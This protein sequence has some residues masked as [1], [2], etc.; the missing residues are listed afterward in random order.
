MA[1]FGSTCCIYRPRAP[2]G[3]CNGVK[4]FTKLHAFEYFLKQNIL[5]VTQDQYDSFLF[6]LRISH[7]KVSN[8][9]YFIVFIVRFKSELEI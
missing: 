3:G 9:L 4:A 8:V 2:A 6:F 7:V 1:G 5:I